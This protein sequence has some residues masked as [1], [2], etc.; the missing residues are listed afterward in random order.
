M[1]DPLYT[2][3]KLLQLWHADTNFPFS[4]NVVTRARN[5]AN[6][7]L[8]QARGTEELTEFFG[9]EPRL[10]LSGRCTAELNDIRQ[11]SQLVRVIEV[12]T[13]IL[14]RSVWVAG[15]SVRM[16]RLCFGYSTPGGQ[17]EARK[18]A[19]LDLCG[20]GNGVQAQ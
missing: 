13:R 17:R 3:K 14:S 1:V 9:G 19:L 11:S 2:L 15:K 5:S 16:L 8:I 18:I 4:K 20:W 7:R 6:T 12:L 10:Q